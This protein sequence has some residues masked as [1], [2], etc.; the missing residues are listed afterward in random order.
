VV[1]VVVGW[2]SGDPCDVLAGPL[3]G[4]SRLA[5]CEVTRATH[6]HHEVTRATHGNTHTL[7]RGCE[8]VCCDVPVFID[9]SSH[10]INFWI[11]IRTWNSTCVIPGSMHA[12]ICDD[13]AINSPNA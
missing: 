4:V 8:R 5:K 1:L 6:D 11:S 12:Q 7:D 13:Q 9:L 10:H 2:G 3:V